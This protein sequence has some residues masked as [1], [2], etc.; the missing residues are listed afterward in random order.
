MKPK[1]VSAAQLVQQCAGEGRRD[2]GG[3]HSARSHCLEGCRP[4]RSRACL[5]HQQI[6][7]GLQVGQLGIATATTAL[8]K[9]MAPTFVEH[10]WVIA[11][12]Q[13][14]YNRAAG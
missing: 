1:W 10:C 5:A 9:R 11:C 4:A 7:E 2:P 8:G 12:V 6:D 13:R 14:R 3:A